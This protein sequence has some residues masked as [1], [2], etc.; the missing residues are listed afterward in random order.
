M[1]DFKEGFEDGQEVISRLP[2]YMLSPLL[3]SQVE[4]LFSFRNPRDQHVSRLA[5]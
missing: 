3:S 1:L 2:S 5:V 4:L